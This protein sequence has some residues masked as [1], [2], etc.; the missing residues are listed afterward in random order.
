MPAR[1]PYFYPE[2]DTRRRVRELT[3]LGWS[4]LDIAEALGITRTRVY[5]HRAKIRQA[6]EKERAS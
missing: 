3:E 4:A 5:Q 1:T 2:S 6:A